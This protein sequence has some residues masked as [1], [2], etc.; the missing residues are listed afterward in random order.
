MEQLVVNIMNLYSE[1]LYHELN[2]SGYLH[3]VRYD[4]VEDVIYF[5][6]ENGYMIILD[7]KFGNND[8]IYEK[9]DKIGKQLAN[10][11]NYDNDLYTFTSCMDTYK[12]EIYIN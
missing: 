4:T 1:N 7:L 10:K 9:D 12:N 11:Y 8:L 2:Q 5:N 6:N 3:N